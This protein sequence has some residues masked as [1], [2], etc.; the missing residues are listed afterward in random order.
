MN[1]SSFFS[2]RKPSG[3]SSRRPPKVRITIRLDREILDY[4]RRMAVSEGK[5]NYQTFINDA[6][7]DYIKAENVPVQLLVSRILDQA[8][9][10]VKLM[11]AQAQM[12]NIKRLEDHLNEQRKSSEP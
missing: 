1:L 12:A 2:T 9:A 8:I 4:F 10:E 11:K 3:R 6:L 7:G 5:G